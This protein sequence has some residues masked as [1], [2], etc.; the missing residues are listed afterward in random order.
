MNEIMN[1]GQDFVSWVIVVKLLIVLVLII[2]SVRSVLKTLEE[3]L[4]RDLDKGFP[5]GHLTRTAVWIL[6]TIFITL[7]LFFFFGTKAPTINAMEEPA[8]H[9]K[10]V[11]EA[12][13]A[14]T[15]SELKEAAENQKPEVLKRQSD[16]SAAKEIQNVMEEVN[17]ITGK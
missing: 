5:K 13:E 1:T 2:F 10:M 6:V 4:K 16:P 15:A 8:G 9:V 14:P 11:Q 12:K 7:G 17:Q 3:V